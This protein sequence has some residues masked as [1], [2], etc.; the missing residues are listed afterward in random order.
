MSTQNSALFDSI[1]SDVTTSLAPVAQSASVGAAAAAGVAKSNYDK[2]VALRNLS[3]FSM[4][5]NY[6]AC[7]RMWAMSKLRAATTHSTR[8]ST[9][10]FAFGHAVGAG[11]A[12][13]DQTGNIRDAIWAAFL[14]WDVDLLQEGTSPTGKSKGESFWEAIQA[15]Q[16]YEIFLQSELDLSAYQVVKLEATLVVDFEDGHFYTGHIDELLQNPNTG[17]YLVKENKTT[18]F[19]VVDPALYSNSEQTLSY[20]VIVDMLGGQ[21]YTVLYTIYSKP[22]QRWITFEF[23]KSAHKKAEW[24]QD[25]LLIHQQRDDYIAANFFPKRGASC[26]RFNRR[27]E[28]YETCDTSLARTYGIRFDQLDT[29]RSKEQ[30][31]E[32]ETIDYFTTLTALIN[33]QKDK[34]NE[35]N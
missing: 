35:T 28:F 11:V 18:G 2:L 17:D 9:P 7:P 21:S 15:I 14:A 16:Q 34:L 4:D 30:L 5:S 3:S 12:T 23:V 13:Y 19:S 8:T 6:H 25:Q 31:Q 26:T 32:I 24:L 27:C 10:T 20:S 33:R 29:L 22:T 1:L